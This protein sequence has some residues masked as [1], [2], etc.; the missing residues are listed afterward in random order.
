MP[1]A[2]ERFR[3]ERGMRIKTLETVARQHR[4]ERRRDRDPALGVEPVGAMRDKSV[5][6][7]PHK[8]GSIRA[9]L[10]RTWPRRPVA[11]RNS[12]RRLNLGPGEF[13]ITWE[14]LGV[15]GIAESAPPRIKN[16][17]PM[18]RRTNAR[19]FAWNAGFRNRPDWALAEL[20]TA[21]RLPENYR[22][23][24]HR[25]GDRAASS[26]PAPDFPALDFRWL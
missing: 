12:A 15:N 7:Q 11:R 2:I 5:H 20:S 8:R 25:V 22:Q 19:F 9:S 21:D 4:P 23:V 3:V 16:M 18:P 1:A 14:N 10:P 24:R 26:A 6:S 17:T 13:G